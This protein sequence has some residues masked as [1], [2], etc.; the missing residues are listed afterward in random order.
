MNQNR[1]QDQSQDGQELY[2]RLLETYEP[3]TAELT[4]IRIDHYN[5]KEVMKDES[6]AN[7]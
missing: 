3:E 1:K 5:D 2:A 6:N 4:S 7:R